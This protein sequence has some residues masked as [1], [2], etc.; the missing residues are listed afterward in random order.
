MNIFKK[1]CLHLPGKHCHKSCELGECFRNISG[2]VNQN[3]IFVHSFVDGTEFSP[4]A[5]SH[6]DSVL[7]CFFFLVCHNHE[8]E[9]DSFIILINKK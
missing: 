5:Q 9:V 3:T 8:L 7:F 4:K 1:F 2:D 6:V